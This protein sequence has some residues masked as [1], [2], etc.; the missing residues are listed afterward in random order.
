MRN[1]ARDQARL[2]WVTNNLKLSHYI[3]ELA[4]LG[5][6][7][8]ISLKQSIWDRAHLTEAQIRFAKGQIR[9]LRPHADLDETNSVIREGTQ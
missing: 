6:A 3:Y 8:A 5:D 2:D 4:D 7:N 1:N 9:I